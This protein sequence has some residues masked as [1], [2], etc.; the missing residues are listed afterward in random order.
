MPFL[1][2]T[3]TCHCLVS[4][5]DLRQH[6]TYRISLL[7][8]LSYQTYPKATRLASLLPQSSLHTPPCIRVAAD[9]Q[10][11]DHVSCAATPARKRDTRLAAAGF[12][13]PSHV[14]IFPKYTAQCSQYNKSFQK[15]DVA[16]SKSQIWLVRGIPFQSAN[17]VWCSQKMQPC[18]F[19]S[20][21]LRSVR[22]APVHFE[23]TNRCFQ[24]RIYIYLSQACRC[25]L[26]TFELSPAL[27][28]MMLNFHS[29][30]PFF[31]THT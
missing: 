4:D 7:L 13:P 21:P 25:V 1:R 2:V 3:N 30:T 17:I 9:S 19:H 20:I 16:L 6:T 23:H 24:K 28:N 27:K 10:A 5:D 8:L 22:N 15:Q 29:I 31:Q 18:I 14:Y 11:A 12:R 26:Q